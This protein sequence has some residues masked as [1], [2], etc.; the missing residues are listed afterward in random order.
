M[1][2]PD[3]AE[4]NPKLSQPLCLSQLK[5][6]MLAP[7]GTA[8]L[9]GWGSLV[10]ADHQPTQALSDPETSKQ[11]SEQEPDVSPAVQAVVIPETTIE[12]S[13]PLTSGAIATA[14]AALQTLPH[15]RLSGS[16]RVQILAVSDYNRVTS[17]GVLT[18][19]GFQPTQTIIGGARIAQT[20]IDLLQQWG[21]PASQRTA[22]PV[23]Y[24]NGAQ[25]LLQTLVDQGRHYTLATVPGSPWVAVASL[26]QADMG[27][28]QWQ[29][30]FAGIFVALGGI[31]TAGLTRSSKQMK[32][33][34]TE[35]NYALEQAAAG[36]W[37]VEVS[38]QGSEDVQKLAENFKQFTSKA[39]TM[40]SNQAEA[41]KQAQFY[42][43]L[44]QAA[45]RGDNQT[46]FNLAVNLAKQH[47]QAERVVVYRFNADWG[48]EIVAEAVDPN[49]PRALND[50]IS[51]PCIPR[52]LLEEYRKGRIVPTSDVWATN[53]SAAHKQLLERLRVRANLVV[54]IVTTDRLLGI[55]V[56]HQCSSTREWQPEEITFLRELG[57][58]VGLS[59]T[60]LSLAEQKAAEAERA[61]VL[62]DITLRI[63]Q[64]LE[65][66]KILTLSV[67]EV[68]RAIKTDRIVIYRF[69][70][71]WKD[72]VVIAE[73]VGGNWRRAMGQTIE[74]PLQEG[75]IERY[76][77]GQVW[78]MD[79]IQTAN[80]S[81]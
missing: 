12:F 62:K 73:S 66:D 22:Q 31:F 43:D 76:S 68:R 41:L 80:L 46:V 18:P 5:P 78:T 37:D 24:S 19:K 55:M 50:K 64:S 38:P 49:W 13:Q 71:G 67:E 74:D 54:P 6:W 16:Q 61:Q 8:A 4:S 42:V 17:L 77:N 29:L 40:L 57:A 47:M 52:S 25:S 65:L 9:L 48:G 35:L 53:Y 23:Q 59:L 30:A 44:A 20:A 75:A 60:N 32:H 2:R 81:S 56:A 69:N 7:L 45:S 27:N 33:S 1:K 51:D 72:G 39:K 58:Q 10:A 79:A 63:R 21:I 36:N 26:T 11:Q 3:A 34:L 15:S 70:P 28:K 14:E